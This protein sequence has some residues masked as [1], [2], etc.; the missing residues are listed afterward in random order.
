[1]IVVT[2]ATGQLDSQIAVDLDDVAAA[3][4]ELPGRVIRRIIVEDEDFVAGR[5]V[6][7]MPETFARRFP[8]TYLASRRG[9]FAVTDPTLETLLDREPQS[10]RSAQD[11]TVTE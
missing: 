7:G 5:I 4:S 10:I 3:L 2:G 11:T 8:D 6:H 1:V 9:E